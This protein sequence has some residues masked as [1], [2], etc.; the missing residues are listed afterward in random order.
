[1]EIKDSFSL[2]DFFFPP[3]KIHYFFLRKQQLEYK[4]NEFKIGLD[5]KLVAGIFGYMKGIFEFNKVKEA[6]L[7][8]LTSDWIR[9]D[10]TVQKKRF[11][12]KLRENTKST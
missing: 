8:R 2:N 7:G 11:F 6:K 10:A 3:Q 9:S 4:A 12:K 1:M 5:W